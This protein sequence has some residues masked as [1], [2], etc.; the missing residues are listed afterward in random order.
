MC[1][2]LFAVPGLKGGPATYDKFVLEDRL[3]VT[4]VIACFSMR[5]VAHLPQS[6]FACR[7]QNSR[8]E[9]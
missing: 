9:G 4:G 6:E 7:G 2:Q 1:R 3:F 8:V 5:C